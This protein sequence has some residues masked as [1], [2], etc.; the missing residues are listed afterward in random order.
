MKKKKELFCKSPGKY[1]VN[2]E[3]GENFGYRIL[4]N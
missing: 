3:N 4:S 1:L 2:L